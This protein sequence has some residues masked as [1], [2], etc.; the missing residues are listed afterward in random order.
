MSSEPMSHTSKRFESQT[1]RASFLDLNTVH[2]FN[3][4]DASGTP[5]QKNGSKH[6]LEAALGVKS[7]YVA[8]LHESLIKFLDDLA[9]KSIRLFS[10]YFYKNE[11]YQANLSDPTYL[12]KSIKHIGRVTLQSKDEVTECKDFKALQLMLSVDLEETRRRITIKYILPADNLHCLALK[13]R[14]QLSIC[15]L[16]ASAALGFIAE[17][18]IK[19]YN[20]HDAI[21][22]LLSTSPTSLLTSPIARSYQE[23]ALLYKEEH[24]LKFV[25]LPT[26]ENKVL[27]DAL[28]E[29]NG[30]ETRQ[31]RI[32]ED[33]T[34]TENTI[35]TIEYNNTNAESTISTITAPVAEE[36]LPPAHNNA[37]L[38]TPTTT[39]PARPTSLPARPPTINPYDK[40][41]STNQPSAITPNHKKASTNQPLAITPNHIPT[42]T[43]TLAPATTTI[44]IQWSQPT[45]QPTTNYFN[46]DTG[47]PYGQYSQDSTNAPREELLTKLAEFVKHAIHNPITTYHAT[48]SRTIAT[49]RILQATTPSIYRTTAQR[50]AA[51]IQKEPPVSHPTLTGLISECTRKHTAD[52]RLKLKSLQDQQKANPAPNNSTPRL[53]S[54]NAHG[55]SN[56]IWNRA[57]P[58]RNTSNQAAA[59]PRRFIQPNTTSTKRTHHQL[60]H[61]TKIQ[62]AHPLFTPPPHHIHQLTSTTHTQERDSAVT[63]NDSTKP[64]RKRGWH[65]SES[66]RNVS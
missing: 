39:L 62:T 37:T 53:N 36:Q 16:L 47:F 58:S 40:S 32:M 31:T 55:S 34:I 66:R 1:S 59:D 7:L 5:N 64:A 24:K 49:K 17:I 29:I 20:E 14:F 22:D 23:F 15:R 21:M 9:E 51:A 33:A 13:R 45:T 61:P 18:D 26:T 8:T 11:K 46:D 42:T 44:D 35:T 56:L 6:P 57:H 19:N 30:Y 65:H 63:P 48:H 54:K 3:P 60:Q 50:I 27:T 52:L 41:A 2:V 38:A 10:D 12:P 4:S 28:N 43:T 25:P